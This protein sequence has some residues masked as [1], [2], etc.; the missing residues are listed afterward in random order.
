MSFKKFSA[1]QDP[2][3]KVDSDDSVEKAPLVDQPPAPAKNAPA[4]AK[5]TT[6]S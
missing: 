5:P 3:T 1:A 2:E 4:E 6:E